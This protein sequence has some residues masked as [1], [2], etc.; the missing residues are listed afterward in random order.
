MVPYSLT[1]AALTGRRFIRWRLFARLHAYEIRVRFE[2]NLHQMHV[3]GWARAE[4]EAEHRAV[5]HNHLSHAPHHLFV[6]AVFF[7]KFDHVVQGCVEHFNMVF[8]YLNIYVALF[9][10]VHLSA[11]LLGNMLPFLELHSLSIIWIEPLTLTH[12]SSA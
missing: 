11:C 8:A 5:A 7:G 1:V 2:E 9:E 6:N 12:R 3:P 10:L 4:A